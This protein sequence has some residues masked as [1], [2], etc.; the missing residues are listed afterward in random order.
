MIT[1]WLIIQINGEILKRHKVPQVAATGDMPPGI[2][3]ILFL[4][5]SEISDYSGLQIE[6]EDGSIR[7]VFTKIQGISNGRSSDGKYGITENNGQVI[8]DIFDAN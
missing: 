5:N 8:L 1:S 4:R 6:D 7:Q 2:R 3:S